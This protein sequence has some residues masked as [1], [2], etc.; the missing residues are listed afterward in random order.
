MYAMLVIYVGW[1]TRLRVGMGVRGMCAE[2]SRS[3]E[4]GCSLTRGVLK[5]DGCLV[6]DAQRLNP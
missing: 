3:A 5:N 6:D 2:H 1:V 4:A